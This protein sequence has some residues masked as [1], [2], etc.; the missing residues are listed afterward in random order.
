LGVAKIR[1]PECF[2]ASHERGSGHGIID[3]RRG[4]AVP[5][6]GVFQQP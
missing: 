1:R 2:S 6:G 5:A 4:S 3:L